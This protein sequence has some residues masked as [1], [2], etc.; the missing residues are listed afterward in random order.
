MNRKKQRALGVRWL[1]RQNG[2]TEAD[3]RK[4]G[5]A[6]VMRCPFHLERTGSF[7]IYV[8]RRDECPNHRRNEWGQLLKP[9]GVR[10][11]P[12]HAYPP[13]YEV[14]H[15]FGCQASGDAAELAQRLRRKNLPEWARHSYDAAWEEKMRLV[16][17]NHGIE[18]EGPG[19]P[20]DDWVPF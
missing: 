12:K 3:F 18:W 19:A 1:L 4:T 20:P 14:G 9:V 5:D 17:E 11:L 10:D 16:G 8:V 2:Y 6:W 13:T 15:C 7:R